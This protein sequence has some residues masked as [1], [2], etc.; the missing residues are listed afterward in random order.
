LTAG[1]ILA[2]VRAHSSAEESRMSVKPIPE[3]FHTIT[4]YL[5]VK[6]VNALLDFVAKAFGAEI[7]CFGCGAGGPRRRTRL[8]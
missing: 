8:W 7:N 5:T 4:P 3:G 1:S 6:G 2:I